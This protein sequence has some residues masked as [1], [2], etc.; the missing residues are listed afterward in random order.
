SPD[1]ICAVLMPGR[2]LLDANSASLTAV[3]APPKANTASLVAVEA[4]HCAVKDALMLSKALQGLIAALLSLEGAISSEKKLPL[5]PAL[6]HFVHADLAA[7]FFGGF[8][9]QGRG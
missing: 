5:W 9:D 8:E 3:E 6:L 2:A 4:L 7:G 1:S